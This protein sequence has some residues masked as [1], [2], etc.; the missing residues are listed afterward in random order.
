[1][2]QAVCYICGSDKYVDDHHIDCR[3]GTRS[4]ETVP[5]CRRCHRTYHMY[6]GIHMFDDEYLDKAIEIENK[7][8][9]IWR[10]PPMKREDVKRSAYWNKT[11]GVKEKKA[12][13]DK[14]KSREDIVRLPHGTPLC[15]WDWVKEHMNDKLPVLAMTVSFNGSR[16]GEFASNTKRGG[17][18]RAITKAVLR[19]DR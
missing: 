9:E 12:K 4:P 2:K 5:L 10:E 17:V 13:I 7:R 18:K 15:G 1:M 11:H 3:E 6:R 8:R 19:R 14:G 16:I